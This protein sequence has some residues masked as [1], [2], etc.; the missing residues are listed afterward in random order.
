MLSQ[1]TGMHEGVAIVSQHHRAAAE[2][3]TVGRLLGVPGWLPLSERRIHSPLCACRKWGCQS[4]S[5]RLELLMSSK[6]YVGA[7][8]VEVPMRP[9]FKT[10]SHNSN[11]FSFDVILAVHY[12]HTSYFCGV[13]AT[14]DASEVAAPGVK[15]ES[16]LEPNGIR[17]GRSSDR[18][19]R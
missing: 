9:C 5:S 8:A 18:L 7:A 14:G 11:H 4:S 6:R 2:E 12:S 15:R 16:S 10:R 1:Q 13:N 19:Q 17:R 3:A